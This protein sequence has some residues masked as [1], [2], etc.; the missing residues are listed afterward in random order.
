MHI[1]SQNKCWILFMLSN[2]VGLNSVLS[3]VC[4]PVRGE[5]KLGYVKWIAMGF[6]VLLTSNKLQL[7]RGRWLLMSK[8]D[9]VADAAVAADADSVFFKIYY[10]FFL[11]KYFF[12]SLFLYHFSI[13]FR[14][15][16][17]NAL[18][19]GFN[20]WALCAV[21]V[22]LLSLWIFMVFFF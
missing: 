18:C 17:R 11:M 22:I 5:S 3:T 10:Y 1:F 13:W 9:A 6:S 15:W 12:L 8:A 7:W 16:I 4:V 19:N 20:Y 2:A 21:C 14:Y